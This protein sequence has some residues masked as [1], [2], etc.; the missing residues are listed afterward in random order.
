MF[1]YKR[2]GCI[3]CYLS[4]FP[5]HL[6]SLP[7]PAKQG[8]QPTKVTEQRRNQSARQPINQ[9]SNQKNNQPS[10][11]AVNNLFVSQSNNQ[12]TVKNWPFGLPTL[13][14]FGGFSL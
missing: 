4:F 14:F 10:N 1:Y 3:A 8:K 13:L 12:G 11:Q 7:Q 9:S 2:S 5:F 6:L